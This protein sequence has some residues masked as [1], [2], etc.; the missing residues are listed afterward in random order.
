MY[1]IFFIGPETDHWH[2]FKTFYPNAIR[3]DSVLSWQDIQSKSFTKMFWVIWDDIEFN[4]SLNLSDYRASKWDDKY[5]HIFKNDNTFNGVCLFPKNLNPSN[6]EFSR[7]FFIQRKEV[8]KVLSTPKYQDTAFDVVFISYDES[9]ADEN[10]A[11]LKQ[12]VPNAKR[13][14]G[15]NGIHNAHIE[16]AKIANSSMFYV[17]DGDAVIED[18]FEFNK[19]ISEFERDTVYV[20]R[21]K[22]PIND[23]EYGY[24]GVKLLPTK[25]TLMLDKNTTDMSTSISGKFKPMPDISNLSQFNTDPFSTW[26]SAFRE[27]AKLAS[28]AIDRQENN[29]T[30]KRLEIWTT[31][32]HNRPFG[33]YSIKGARAGKEFGLSNKTDILLIND[34]SWLRK[35]FEDTCGR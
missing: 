6:R 9:N 7:R 26:K 11:I 22:N 3:I 13:I 25:Y 8:D 27:C 29:E 20:W 31:V 2:K 19:N 21:S 17:V 34:F 33:E 1:D 5:V 32:G 30:N 28:K 15:V 4:Y 12:K 18:T 23:L 24:G 35:K 14:H 16:A 10:F